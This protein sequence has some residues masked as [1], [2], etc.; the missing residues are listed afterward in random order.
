GDGFFAMRSADSGRTLYTRNGAFG[1]DEAGYI[2]DGSNNRLQVF[3]TDAAGNITST[4]PADARIPATNGGGAE[5]AGITVSSDGRVS[6]SYAD[7]SVEAIGSVAL[8]SF[9]APTGLK[10]VGSS[11]WEATGISGTAAFGSPGQGQYGS[12]LSG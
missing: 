4:T 6:A 3:P 2:N 10:Q 1:I 9:I 5:F 8:A 11:N 12:L 7:G